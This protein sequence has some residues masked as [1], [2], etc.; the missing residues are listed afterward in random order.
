M[1]AFGPLLA[2]VTIG[3]FAR[4]ASAQAP[5]PTPA[6]APAPQPAPQP[7]PPPPSPD[8]GD[9]KQLMQTGVR[10]LEAHDYLGALEVFKSAYER[11]PSAK[12][13][14]NIGTTL[15]LLERKCEAANAYQRYLDASDSDPARRAEV[16]DVLADL[17]KG[18]AQLALSVDPSDADLEIGNERINAAHDKLLRVAPGP[19]VLRAHREGFQ[20]GEQRGTVALGEHAVVSIKLAA[21]PVAAPQ[22]IERVV[23]R[24]VPAQTAAIGDRSRLAGVVEARVSVVPK[25][26]SAYLIGASYDINPHLAVEAELLL[27]PG[28]A[29]TATGYMGPFVSVGAYAGASYEFLTD[30]WRPRVSAGLPMFSSSGEL[31]FTGRLA[32]GVEY[33]ASRHFSLVGELGAELNFNPPS[34]IKTFA[35]VPTLAATG[36]L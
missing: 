5:A 6:P 13:L 24:D 31:R 35:L 29:Y 1:R 16:T 4:I 23:T 14:L 22:V 25:V 17:D 36:R 12:I 33:V 27:G 30:H 28:L 2:I 15:K 10:L 32:G 3:L 7:P 20:P 26:G 19:Y 9:A 34:D 8:R 18:C 21:N 11:F